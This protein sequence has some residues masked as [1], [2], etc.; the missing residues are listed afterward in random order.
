MTSGRSRSACATSAAL[1]A[2]GWVGSGSSSRSYDRE[3]R[4]A[5]GRRQSRECRLHVV[6][7]LNEQQLR[8]RQV[9]PG[10]ADV[11]SGP[12]IARREGRHLIDD[13]LARIDRILCHPLHRPGAER[14]EVR[15]IDL[16]QH[17]GATAVDLLALR[18]SAEADALDE[19]V[20]AAEVGDQLTDRESRRKPIEN[21]RIVQPASGDSTARLPPAPRSGSRRPWESTQTSPDERS[22]RPPGPR[23]VRR[24]SVDDSGSPAVRRL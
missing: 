11:E 19:I 17:V 16:Q 1:S 13:Q 10:K 21:D 20:R 5:H 2:G 18:V 6:A 24:E 4:K 15:A 8:F 22:R 23:T 3:L 9:H 7:R 12:E 14:V